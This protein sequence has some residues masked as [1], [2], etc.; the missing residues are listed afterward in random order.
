MLELAFRGGMLFAGLQGHAQGGLA[1]GVLGDADDAA[2]HGA[3]VAR[4]WRRRRHGA[5]ETEG[6]PKRWP[7]R[8]RCRPELRRA[9]SGA[10]GPAGRR[11]TATVARMALRAA[12]GRRVGDFAV[13]SSGYC[14]RA[15]NFLW[16]GPARADDQFEAEVGG[17]GA[18]R[19]GSAGRRLIDEEGLAFALEMRRAMA[20]ASAAAVAS[21]RAG[22]LAS[23]SP[24]RSMT[25]CWKFSSAS[26]RPGRSRPGRV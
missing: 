20:M 4:G 2:R 13:A 12:I 21:S 14:S 10:P 5:A 25:I 26:R 1:A 19:R 3:D 7:S 16:G 18:P 11:A 15:P 6:T 24:V 17:A 23:S 9:I 22:A 8:G